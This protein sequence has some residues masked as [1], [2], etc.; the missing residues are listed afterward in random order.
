ML[1]VSTRVRY[2]TRALVHIAELHPSHAVPVKLIARAQGL[3]VKYLEHI[4]SSL[5]AAGLIRS[6]RGMQGGYA[7]ARPPRSIRLDEVVRALDGPPVIVECVDNPES[8][9]RNTICPT[10]DVWIRVRKAIDGVL[11]GT[12][13]EDLVEVSRAKGKTPPLSYTI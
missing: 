1:K 2:G 11:S 8:C 9:C 12:T 13:L 7:L 6:V 4:V 3:S 10:R 5:K